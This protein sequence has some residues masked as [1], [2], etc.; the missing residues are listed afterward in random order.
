[1]RRCGTP[2]DPSG[3]RRLLLFAGR[4]TQAANLGPRLARLRTGP[5]SSYSTA[6]F[7]ERGG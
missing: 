7:Q 6:S 1:M 3:A 4:I 5:Q 2:P